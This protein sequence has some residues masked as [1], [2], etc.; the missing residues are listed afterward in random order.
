LNKPTRWS[1]A[2]GA[3]LTV[4]LGLVA[5]AT[6]AAGAAP[7]TSATAAT[8][9]QQP[10]NWQAV[11]DA[12]AARFS[13]GTNPATEAVGRLIDP[14]DYSCGPTDLDAYVD[15][16]LSGLTR[17]QLVALAT[18]GALDFP[19]YDALFFGT[20]GDPAYALPSDYRASLTNTFRDAQKFWDVQSSDIQLMA[21][22]GGGVL[23]DPARL[24][25]LL[26]D[27]YGFSP[28]GAASYAA[29]VV[30]LVASIPALQGGDNPIFTLN[31]FAFSGEGDPDPVVAALPDKLIFGDGILD[32]LEYM[33]IADVG[34]RAVLGHEFG[35]HVQYEDHLFR[36]VSTDAELPEATR[37]TELMA[38]AFGSYFATHSRGLALNAKRVLQVEKSFYEVGDCSFDSP[39]HHGTPSQRLRASEW[40]V[41][42]ATS[43]QTQ[44]HIL[45]SMVVDARFEDALP[46]LVAPD[47]S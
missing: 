10:A 15:Q 38:D 27:V 2:L 26:T 18:S 29:S 14:A 16:I 39:G 35:H 22:H 46:G 6:S 40:G 21:M 34:P 30:K 8:D 43:A 17:A 42:L 31:A 4:A 19:T 25:R 37:R 23:R 45:P 12:T 28:A 5:P 7:V 9:I 24:A 11:R 44:G 3:G 1:A 41:D 36:E 20:T 47:A 13:L 33:N 32:A